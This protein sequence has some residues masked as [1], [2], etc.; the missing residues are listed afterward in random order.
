[1]NSRFEVIP[2]AGHFPF[3]EAPDAFLDLLARF[4]GVNPLAHGAVRRFPIRPAPGLRTESS[5]WAILH[6]RPQHKRPPVQ[7]TAAQKTPAQKAAH[8]SAQS[9]ARKAQLKKHSSKR[10][11][12]SIVHPTDH[13]IK[14][15]ALYKFIRIDEPDALRTPI[16]DRMEEGG[17]R[18]T[19]L[20]AP[21]GI[22]GTVAGEKASMDAF[23]AWLRSMDLFSDLEHKESFVADMPFLRARVRLKKEIVTMA[24]RASTRHPVRVPMWIPLN[25]TP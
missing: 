7:K 16:S 22:N 3:V 1:M 6:C 21:E 5:A 8:N 4:M 12:H 2:E 9:T 11:A 25:G 23:L 18:G 15:A 17:I 24:F 10:T 20:L 14:V 19:L 13:P